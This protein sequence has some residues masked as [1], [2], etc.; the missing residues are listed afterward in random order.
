MLT[1][2]AIVAVLVLGINAVGALMIWGL[3]N[4]KNKRK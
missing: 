2:I 1:V 4:I 3:G